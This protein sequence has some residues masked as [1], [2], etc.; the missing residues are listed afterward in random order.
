MIL[1]ESKTKGDYAV[2]DV[3]DPKKF[4]QWINESS[5]GD[6]K[7]GTINSENR[8]AD[9]INPDQVRKDRYQYGRCC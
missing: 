7:G 8:I 6:S 9:Y 4:A 2:L 3:V 1:N 5:I